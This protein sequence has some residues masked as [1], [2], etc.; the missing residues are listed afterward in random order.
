[1][2]STRASRPG[3]FALIERYFRP[4]AGNAGAFGLVDD[5][6]LYRPAPDEDLVLTVDTIA[7]GIHFMA[8]DPAASIAR[9]ALRVNLSD[10]AAKG[11]T[12][13]GYLL[14]L[15]LPADWTEK[16]IREF[17]KGLEG[18][19]RPSASRCSEAIRRAPQAD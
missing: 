8:D 15:A 14:A 12:P 5:A 10:L 3:E 2:V 11:A 13:V 7:A 18:Y 6:A 1:M 16:W 19:Y 9:K 17:A 4:L